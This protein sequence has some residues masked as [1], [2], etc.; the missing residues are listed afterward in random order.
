MKKCNH[1][2]LSWNAL[3]RLNIQGLLS[4]TFKKWDW[5]WKN[6]T[7]AYFKLVAVRQLT[8]YFGFFFFSQ[9]FWHAQAKKTSV[10]MSQGSPFLVWIFPSF[11]NSSEIKISNGSSSQIQ[12]YSKVNNSTF[13]THRQIDRL[14]FS[15]MTFRGHSFFLGERKKDSKI[16]YLKMISFHVLLIRFDYAIWIT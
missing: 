11:I 5:L 4:V 1:H 13:L 15:L 7:L 10:N 12:I 8:L 3:Q 14:P 6:I 16:F 9:Q 2:L